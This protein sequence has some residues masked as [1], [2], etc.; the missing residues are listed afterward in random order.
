MLEANGELGR[1]RLRHAQALEALL[2]R[3]EA[4]LRTIGFIRWIADIE[5]GFANI[6]AAMH[7]SFESANAP[8]LGCG[9]LAGG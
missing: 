4:G 7:W 9:I 1:M 8:E 6:A 5:A 2:W 3:S